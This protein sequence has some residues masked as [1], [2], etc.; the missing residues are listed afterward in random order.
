MGNPTICFSCATG[1]VL[2]TVAAI[3]CLPVTNYSQS[4]CVVCPMGFILQP[5]STN[6]IACDATCQRCMGTNTSICTSCQDGF[7]L[8]GSQCMAC[9]QGCTSCTS[10]GLCNTCGAGFVA[11]RTLLGN[12]LNGQPPVTQCTPCLAPCRECQGRPDICFTCMPY[13]ALIGGKCIYMQF[14]NVSVTVNSTLTNFLNNYAN[15]TQQIANSVDP[16][17]TLGYGIIFPYYLMSNSANSITYMT[18]ISSI[19]VNESLCTQDEG[20]SI[21]NLAKQS[22]IGNLSVIAASVNGVNFDNNDTNTTN[23]TNATCPP[24]CL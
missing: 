1:Y 21:G 19:C 22:V 6:C 8:N 10:G 9:M 20:N 3:Q 24:G 7:Y 5:N 2:D 14:Y 23:T 17:G 13:Y 11:V 16:Q 18:L 12:S 15:F 4:G